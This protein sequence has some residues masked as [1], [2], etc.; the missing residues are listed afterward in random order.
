MSLTFNNR[1]S[2]FPSDAIDVLAYIFGAG[3]DFVE[4]LYGND[5]RPQTVKYFRDAVKLAPPHFPAN[6]RGVDMAK[7]KRLVSRR[8][9]RFNA[10]GFDLD[11]TCTFIKTRFAIER[12]RNAFARADIKPNLIAMG[13]PAEKLEGIYRNRMEDVVRCERRTDVVHR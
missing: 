1:N 8:K 9:R 3:V 12:S 13:F 10:D 2:P 5:V 6:A 7:I 4:T 11:L